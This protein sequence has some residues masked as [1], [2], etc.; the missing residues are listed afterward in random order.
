MCSEIVSLYMTQSSLEICPA[1]EAEL[2]TIA[3]G[4][5]I[6]ICPAEAKLQKPGEMK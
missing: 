6:N 2:A 1:T 4:C 5:L 3:S